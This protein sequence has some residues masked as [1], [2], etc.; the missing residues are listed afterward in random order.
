MDPNL[1]DRDQLPLTPATVKYVFEVDPSAHQPASFD[2]GR[3][4][5]MNHFFQK[6]CPDVPCR[7]LPTHETGVP[8]IFGRRLVRCMSGWN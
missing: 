7:H 3:L 2:L 6:Q 5:G 4:I 1:L 8:A